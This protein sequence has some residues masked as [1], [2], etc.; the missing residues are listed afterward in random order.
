MA[1]YTP[2]PFYV[3]PGGDM[4]QGLDGLGQVL[5]ENRAAKEEKA[6]QEMQKQRI[7]AAQQ[8]ARQALQSGNPMAVADVAIEYPEVA[9]MLNKQAGIIDDAKKQDATQF[10]IAL[11]A[12]DPDDRAAVYQ[13]RIKQLSDQ[14]RDPSHTMQ[15]YRD[16]LADPEREI[17]GVETMF[18]ATNPD[19]YK[20]YREATTVKP[21]E[22]REI[23]RGDRVVT[24]QW[25]G[26][27]WTQIADAARFNP[28]SGTTVN[29]GTGGAA[30]EVVTPPEL[31]RGLPTEVAEKH[32]AV[33][34]AAGGGKDGLDALNKLSEKLSEQD[35]RAQSENILAASFP[36]ASEDEMT[37]LKAAMSA[38][39]NTEAG[40]KQ[41]RTVR[42][43]QRKTKKGKQF[44]QRAVSLLRKIVD[45]PNLPDVL[46]SL[47][48]SV[49]FLS[50]LDDDE[51]ELIS[52]IEEASNILTAE[53]LDLMSGV[54]SESDIALLKSLSTGGLN[55]RRTEDRFIS[56]VQS[57][58]ERLSNG[59]PAEESE[60]QV[61]RFKVR[62]K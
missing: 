21:A 20:S 40:L 36:N 62:V 16:Y 23:K 9:E 34:R 59:Q 28:N 6:A 27:K 26:E 57:M 50:V 8:A 13:Q 56:D 25:D 32:D 48:G 24:E 54:L 29:V 37:E 11:L 4:S 58:I 38:A 55:R 14:G 30:E 61:G 60:S 22:T 44:Q 33:Y 18:A 7:A 52:D 3:H 51:A 19:A 31:L 17:K 39:E 45:N 42:E 41:A 53:N 12:A 47:E 35:R 5:A 49:D 2:N 10:S 43:D 1:R 15:S 46:G